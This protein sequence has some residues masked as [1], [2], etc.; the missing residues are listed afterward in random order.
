[1]ELLAF[2]LVTGLAASAHCLGMCG[3]FPLHLAHASAPQT[4]VARQALYVAGKAFTYAF[5]GAVAG[6]VGALFIHGE[7]VA[8]SRRILAIA[9]GAIMLLFG[10][11]MVG[12]WPKRPGLRWNVQDWGPIKQLYD[13][14]FRTPGLW[15]AFVL[16][17][18]TGFLPCPVTAA[19][20]IFA[21]GVHS[22]LGGML[23]MAALGVGTAPVLLAVGLS[24]G[25]LSARFRQVGL[26][27]AGVVVIL[28]GGLTL[29]RGT[30][31]L[32][33]HEHGCPLHSP[34][35]VSATAHE[36]R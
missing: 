14:F 9:A 7:W 18:L 31:V 15:A 19:V 32:P 11:Q 29:L 20:L 2:G 34:T 23:V 21:A 6:Y 1:M 17:M 3:G 12:L 22:A 27:A 13:H 4:L 28:L 10:L 8:Q 36:P 26:R 5:L 16:G 35:T 25:L 33:C 30:G 24:G